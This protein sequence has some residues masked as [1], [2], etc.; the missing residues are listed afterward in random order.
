MFDWDEKTQGLLLSGFYY[1][2]CLSQILGGFLA[3]KF[4]SKWVL[5]VGL[6]STAIFTFLTPI[7]TRMGGSTSLFIL[8]ILEGIGEVIN[9]SHT[10]LCQFRE[11]SIIWQLSF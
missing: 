3:L 11:V 8:R 10:C 1:G 2:Y 6:L 5:G 7:V 4:G 9:F